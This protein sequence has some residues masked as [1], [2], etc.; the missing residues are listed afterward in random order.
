[1]IPLLALSFITGATK[2]YAGKKKAA[3][4][5]TA[6]AKKL[7]AERLYNEQSAALEA[8]RQRDLEAFKSNLRI[9][10]E[11][12]KTDAQKGIEAASGQNFRRLISVDSAVPFAE[13]AEATKYEGYDPDAVFSARA[14]FFDADG[15]QQ[16]YDDEIPQMRLLQISLTKRDDANAA[17]TQFTN[18]VSPQTLQWW[19]SNNQGRYDQAVSFLTNSVAQL[20]KERGSSGIQGVSE[21]YPRVPSTTVQSLINS[22]G[23]ELTEQIVR[24][25]MPTIGEDVRE[26]YRGLNW[27]LANDAKIEPKVVTD[28]ATNETSIVPE[29]EEGGVHV[30]EIDNADGTINRKAVEQLSPV[31]KVTGKTVD[32]VE[33][34]IAIYA[35]KSDRKPLDMINSVDATRKI[36]KNNSWWIYPENSIG[37]LDA[38]DKVAFKTFVGDNGLYSDLTMT[39]SL[40]LT[41]MLAGPGISGMSYRTDQREGIVPAHKGGM[42]NQFVAQKPGDLQEKLAAETDR[43][44]TK[45]GYDVAD[46]RNKA[47]AAKDAAISV[48]ALIYEYTY[49]KSVPGLAGSFVSGIAGAKAQVG[50]FIQAITSADMDEAKKDKYLSDLRGL[51]TSLSVEGL[52]QI[53]VANRLREYH[54]G[55]LV[56]S[57]AMALQGGNA[58][59]RTISDADIERISQILAVGNKLGTTEQKVAVMQALKKELERRS[60]IAEYYASGKESKA[61]SAYTTEQY[62]SENEY[63]GQTVIDVLYTKFVDPNAGTTR[64]PAGAVDRP[65]TRPG[66]NG[67]TLYLQPNKSYGRTP[68]P[69]MKYDQE[70]NVG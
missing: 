22:Y 63:G 51:Q 38:S 25:S 66:P 7:E 14:P 18:K 12:A 33:A 3:S 35:E 31:A 27:N 62:L 54:E 19:Q 47:Q 52:D 37:M 55:V 60:A 61:W 5:A 1:M 34:N 6:E 40:E 39:E 8:E 69:E 21:G 17:I 46:V 13:L 67:G 10:E 57:M 56:Y 42:P 44:S 53:A 41:E 59:A 30:P 9:Q 58:A 4:E 16:Y 36:F 68:H 28:V 23:P 26:Y 20:A 2:A 64:A 48:D 50:Y 29:V 11:K 70:A 24:D 32:K 43:V 65:L 45:Y 15:R 49:G